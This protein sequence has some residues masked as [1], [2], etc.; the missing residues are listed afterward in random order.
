MDLTKIDATVLKEAFS[1]FDVDNTNFIS[2]ANLV[3]ALARTGRKFP[4]NEINS[5][6]EEVDLLKNNKITYEEF[7]EFI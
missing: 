2:Q 4:D 7:V 6:L 3:E 1:Y 5:M